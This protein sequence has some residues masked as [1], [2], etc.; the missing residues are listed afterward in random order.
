MISW[1]SHYPVVVGN[2]LEKGGVYVEKDTINPTISHNLTKERN[3]PQRIEFGRRK[4]SY[5]VLQDTHEGD[6]LI[7]SLYLD[8][9]PSFLE[10]TLWPC[11]G[12]DVGQEVTLPAQR[13]YEEVYRKWDSLVVNS[14]D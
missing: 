3:L 4:G 11:F 14:L 5:L 13:R 9:K 2:E 7:P 8:E 12:P 10:N 1:E 6:G